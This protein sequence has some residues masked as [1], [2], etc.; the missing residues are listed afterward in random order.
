MM[1][2]STVLRALGRAALL[3]VP[4]VAAAIMVNTFLADRSSAFSSYL[5]AFNT[6]YDTTGTRLDT[7]GT[8]HQGFNTSAWNDYGLDLQAQVTKGTPI[9]DAL[10][11]IEGDDSDSDGFTNLAEINALCF[12]GDPT[13]FPGSTSCPVAAATATPV[14]PTPTTEPPTATATV[15]PSTSTPVPTA[16]S[17]SEPP[18]ATATAIPSTSTPTATSTTEPP[19]AT[20][21]VV[22]STSTPVPTATSTSIPPPTATRPPVGDVCESADLDDDG[23]VDTRDLVQIAKQLG[24]RPYD[25]RLDLNNDGKVKATDLLIVIRCRF[26]ERRHGR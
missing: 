19:T 24:R 16:T 4:L 7:C 8:C 23:D 26:A 22:P 11:N 25:V 1:R 21:T 2:T 14:P 20:A 15:V 10:V 12:P 9:A 3:L 13:D 5:G 6:A 18:T 17:T